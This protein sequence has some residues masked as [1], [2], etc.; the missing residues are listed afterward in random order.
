MID[1]NDILHTTVQETQ[2]FFGSKTL[3][4][5]V[6]GK[7]L[8]TLE[9]QPFLI[10][11]EQNGFNGLLFFKPITTKLKITKLRNFIYLK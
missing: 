10:C 6:D 2:V 8:Q 7:N 3:V 5:F 11:V 1:V 9:R 4:E